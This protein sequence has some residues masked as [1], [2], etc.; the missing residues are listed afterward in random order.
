MGGEHPATDDAPS[1]NTRR[2]LVNTSLEQRRARLEAKKLEHTRTLETR[3]AEIHK[4][5]Q[6]VGSKILLWMHKHIT[7][8]EFAGLLGCK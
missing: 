8:F 5:K 1:P 7:G 4:H 6:S 3:R 2:Q